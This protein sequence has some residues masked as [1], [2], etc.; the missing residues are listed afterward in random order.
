[1]NTIMRLNCKNILGIFFVIFLSI[2]MGF[3][4]FSCGNKTI[5]KFVFI[6]SIYPLFYSAYAH[7]YYSVVSLLNSPDMLDRLAGY[8]GLADMN[9]IDEEF[10]FSRLDKEESPVVKKTLVWLLAHSANKKTTFK[11]LEE[12]W[13]SQPYGVR[14]EILNTLQKLDSKA[15]KEFLERRGIE[16]E[17]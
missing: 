12:I 1:M 9:N 3:L 15:Y 6:N 14:A 13:D 17:E 7:K 16:M 11:R 8:Y 2:G 10:I 5:K 4:G